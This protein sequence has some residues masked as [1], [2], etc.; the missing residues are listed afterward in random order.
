[1]WHA[2]PDLR[3]TADE[4]VQVRN[5]YGPHPLTHTRPPG[6]YLRS[7]S[8]RLASSDRFSSPARPLRRSVIPMCCHRQHRR[9]LLCHRHQSLKNQVHAPLDTRAGG[10]RKWPKV[11]MSKIHCKPSGGLSPSLRRRLRA[12][13]IS[14]PTL[15]SLHL[16][17]FTCNDTS[18][19]PP[20]VPCPPLVPANAQPRVQPPCLHVSMLSSTSS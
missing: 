10:E 6:R 20:P 3:P 18:R 4:L 19:T 2:D 12:P 7:T 15:C 17:L 14:D 8:K 1:M 13:A 11:A 5:E 9:L 16:A